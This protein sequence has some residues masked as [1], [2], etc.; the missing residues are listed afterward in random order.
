MLDCVVLQMVLMMTGDCVVLQMV[1]MMTEDCDG[2]ANQ[3]D[4]G[5]R[6]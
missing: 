6:L 4:D 3:V 2:F 5:R 1:L